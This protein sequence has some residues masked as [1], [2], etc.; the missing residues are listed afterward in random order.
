MSAMSLL[1]FVEVEGAPTRKKEK[2]SYTNAQ[3]KNAN[4]SLGFCEMYNKAKYISLL[5]L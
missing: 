2:G 5:Q 3:M 4:L 1:H